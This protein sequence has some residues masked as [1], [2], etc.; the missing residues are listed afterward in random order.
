ML[1][2]VIAN[3]YMVLLNVSVIQ[4]L[5]HFCLDSERVPLLL[6]LALLMSGNVLL[7]PMLHIWGDSSIVIIPTIDSSVALIITRITLSHTVHMLPTIN[8]LSVQ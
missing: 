6:C 4:R 2:V 3:T 5:T 1:N 8:I 7:Q